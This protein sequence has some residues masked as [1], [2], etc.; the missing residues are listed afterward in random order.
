MLLLDGEQAQPRAGE[1][2]RQAAD[3]A[4]ASLRR[5]RAAAAAAAAAAAEAEA[6]GSGSDADSEVPSF[7]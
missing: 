3:R 1:Q 7:K 5:R 6:Q 2:Q 4:P